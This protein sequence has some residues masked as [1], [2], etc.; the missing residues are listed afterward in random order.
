[1]KTASSQSMS[2]LPQTPEI[3]QRSKVIEY[4]LGQFCDEM[5][6]PD[7][8]PHPW[9]L[10]LQETLNALGSR[11]LAKRQDAAERALFDMGITFN[12]YNDEAATEKIF[13]IDLIPRLVRGQ[14]WDHIER[15]LHQ[16]VRALNAFIHD[17]YNEQRIVTE[18]IIPVE[19]IRSAEGF[20]EPCIGLTPPQGIWCHITGSDLVRDE[21]GAL[22][23]LEDNLRCPSG[24]SYALANR[25]QMKRTFPNLFRSSRVRPISHYPSMLL[26]ML[27]QVA[28]AGNNRPNAA[29]LTPGKYNSAY[30]E[31]SYLA[32]KMGCKLVEGGDLVVED[33]R[34]WMRTTM[35]LQPVDVIYRR[36]DD[37]F[38]DP[39]V[40]R[41]DSMLGVKGLMRAYRAGNV[42]L[43][44][45]PGTGVADDKLIYT[46]VP[47]MI[48]LYLDEE[49]I[50]PNVET[51][52]CEDKAQRQHVLANL[53]KLVVKAVNEAG[54]Y[55][56]LVG[57]HATKAEREKFA[58]LI[59]H[60]PRDYIAQ[61]TLQLS[62][63]P[64]LVE[65]HLEGRH[66]DLRPYILLGSEVVVVPGGLTRVA[67]KKGSLVVNSSQGG[68]SK[69]T[70]VVDGDPA[71]DGDPA[72]AADPDVTDV[73][74]C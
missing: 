8:K 46:Y 59:T 34:V 60:A 64:V 2:S 50:L 15:G 43:V 31:H 7:G 20:L 57:P 58:E 10:G 62:R 44:N 12:V 73:A 14:E 27:N 25:N 13:P 63:A 61:P 17:V 28:P 67:L 41:S 24:V 52:R 29:V 65:D 39:E 30:F 11:R 49:P 4:D 40:F 74:S 51:Y 66:V 55:G 54:G 33:E 18:G 68:G 32:R 47:D 56:M 38:L 70:W 26:Q 3:T 36:I 23:V 21:R 19:T 69:D 1:M 48:R 6:M 22:M 16:R 72:I 5:Y 9:A 45:A 53:D 42:S 35:G 71:M 37:K